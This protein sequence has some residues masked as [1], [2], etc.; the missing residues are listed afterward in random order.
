[1]FRLM[2]FVTVPFTAIY[3]MNRGPRPALGY[4]WFIAALLTPVWIID[5]TTSLKLDF[6]SAAA[7]GSLAGFVLAS[8]VDLPKRWLLADTIASL[9]AMCI[10]FAQ[11]RVGPFGPLTAPDILRRWLLPYVV[12]RLLFRSVRDIKELMPVLS[13][14]LM[15]ISVYAI[16]EAV[17]KIHLVNKILGKTYGLLE[18]GEGYR[19]G[20]KRAQGFTDHPIFFGA[21]LV[22]LLPWAF[23]CMRQAGTGE[24]PKWWHAV[25][26][27]V[28]GAL[29]G[30]VSRGPQLAGILT[31]SLVVFFRFRKW[32]L[33]M[34]LLGLVTVCG[35]YYGK[36]RIMEALGKV[37]GES[38]EDVRIILI[39]GEE[40]E[41]TG[42]KHRVLLL[43][44]Y[45][46][47]IENAGWLGYGFHL[48]GVEVEEHLANRFG[49][50]DCHYILFLLRYGY[51]TLALFVALGVCSLW[52][53]VPIAW[54]PELPHSFLAAGLV[55][56]IG[57]VMLVLASVWFAPDFGTMWLFSAGV[58]SSLHELPRTTLTKQS[59]KTAAI[60]Q[61]TVPKKPVILHPKVHRTPR[62]L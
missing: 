12:G 13:Y 4:A 53:L 2:L 43:S 8:K 27:V 1:M 57:S 50:I 61:P 35:V 28:V 36:D 11:F 59:E 46:N 26:L 24:G 55:G 48:R 6:R 51:L 14:I 21:L 25:P 15:I 29:F 38:D 33:A 10:V 58:A 56:A 22:L 18:Q 39:D 45:R 5:S 20:L 42:T 49:S 34:L 40:V 16:V 62:P 31:T 44:V 60:E 17:T 23:E 37:A 9:L 7:I 52:C 32:R 19:M 47:A 30:T 41:Y 3:A 54:N